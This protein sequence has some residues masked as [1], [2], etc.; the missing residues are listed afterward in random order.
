MK[1]RK[2][3]YLFNRRIEGILDGVERHYFTTILARRIFLP[4]NLG[5]L[6]E[7]VNPILDSVSVIWVRFGVVPHDAQGENSR[8][9]TP[10]SSQGPH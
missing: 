8:Q 2:H 6:P 9:S 3:T 7:V 10:E 4:D 1:L 5:K